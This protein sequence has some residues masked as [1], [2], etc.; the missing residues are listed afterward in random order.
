MQQSH[1]LAYTQPREQQLLPEYA[2]SRTSSQGFGDIHRSYA[3]MRIVPDRPDER[4]VSQARICRRQMRQQ[5]ANVT[6]DSGA[7]VRGAP[8]RVEQQRIQP[9]SVSAFSLGFHRVPHYNIQAA[10]ASRR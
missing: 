1:S 6:V 7:T 2:R 4:C 8:T 9:N 5:A 10:P 3:I